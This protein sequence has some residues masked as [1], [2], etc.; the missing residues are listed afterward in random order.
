MLHY[1]PLFR[2]QNAILS[3]GLERYQL[4]ESCEAP[5]SPRLGTYTRTSKHSAIHFGE[6]TKWVGVKT[7]RSCSV[8]NRIY[9]WTSLN[10]L[11]KIMTYFQDSTWFN[12]SGFSVFCLLN[13]EH[14]ILDQ[15][16]TMPHRV[17]AAFRLHNFPWKSWDYVKLI[18]IASFIFPLWLAFWA[19]EGFQASNI[20]TTSTT[21]MTFFSGLHGH[22]HNQRTLHS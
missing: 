9:V 18:E 16:K 6:N 11:E 1:A 21:K 8:E 4:P 12:F 10:M 22:S 3:D 5:Q 15:D 20:A 19:A 7:C 13:P 14:A 2:F 17:H